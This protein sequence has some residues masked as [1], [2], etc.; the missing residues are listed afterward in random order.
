[1]NLQEKI[2]RAFAH[3]TIPLEV[4]HPAY[5]DHIDSDVEDALTFK[6]KHWREITRQHW[7]KYN[8]AFWFLTQGALFLLSSKP[9]LHPTPSS[10]GPMDM[11]IDKLIHSLDLTPPSSPADYP[12]ECRLAGLTFDEYEA[13][14]EWL[15]FMSENYPDL[16]IGA[17]RGGAGDLFGRAFD[18]IAVLQNGR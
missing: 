2:E 1:M 4:V 10:L 5:L 13:M 18:T 8:C 6:G 12:F 17:A 14:K 16:A 11:A 9:A 3:R 7:S 15:L